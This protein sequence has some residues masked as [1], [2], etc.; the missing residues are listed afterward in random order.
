MVCT[1][2]LINKGVQKFFTFDVESVLFK[3]TKRLQDRVLHLDRWVLEVGCFWK[4]V[5]DKEVWVRMVWLPL[6]F[7][8][9]VFKK[10]GDY[11]GGSVVVDKD[12]TLHHYL[13]W[14]LW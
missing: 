6:H 2:S 7:W 3:G 13:Q 9:Q 11:C 1:D 8:C 4:G 14:A 5:Y 12:T 10:I